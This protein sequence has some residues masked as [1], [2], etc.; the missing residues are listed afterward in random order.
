MNRGKRKNRMAKE[1][2]TQKIN[3]LMAVLIFVLLL[4][5]KIAHIK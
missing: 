4:E 5:T 3:L 1:K 2:L